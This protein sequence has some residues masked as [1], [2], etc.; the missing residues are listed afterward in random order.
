MFSW[1]F[2]KLYDKNYSWQGFDLSF[3]LQG[4]N[5]PQENQCKN[6][7][8]ETLQLPSGVFEK[9]CFQWADEEGCQGRRR[10]E[11]P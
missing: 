4:T 7:A 9:S 3:N 6:W 11:K 10:E 1:Q 8:C 5:N 2:S